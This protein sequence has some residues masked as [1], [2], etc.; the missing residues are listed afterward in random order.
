MAKILLID[1]DKEI[2]TIN[3]RY[4]QDEG[5]QVKA[6]TGA[7]TGLR[8]IGEFQPDCIVLDVMM[9]NMDG[10]TA[11][12]KIREISD[13]P[14]IFLTGRT[15][16]DNKINGLLLGADDYMIKPYS[17]RELSTRIRVLIRRFSSTANA[18]QTIMS[19]PPLSINTLE[20]KAYYNEEVI[21]LTGREYE[22]L[23]LLAS[24]PNTTVT[25]EEIGKALFDVYT[26]ADRRTIT[27]SASRLRKKLADYIGLADY[28]QTVWS[29]GYQF[30]YKI[31]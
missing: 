31:S 9:P 10:F 27:V 7:V 17:L 5:F 3:M 26:E 28:I 11:C 19:F 25:F 6:A 15:D 18:S 30:H 16:E 8:L 21:D 1:D 24:K 22:L 14:I 23:V 12:Q 29:Q 2:L 20:K 13:A 4:L